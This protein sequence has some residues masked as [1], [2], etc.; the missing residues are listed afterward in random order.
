MILVYSQPYLR[1]PE[2]N[3]FHALLSGI[4]ARSCLIPNFNLL[5]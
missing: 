5:R 2:V 1:F 3:A 4:F